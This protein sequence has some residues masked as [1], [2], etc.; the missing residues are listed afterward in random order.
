MLNFVEMHSVVLE[1]FQQALSIGMNA[2]SFQRSQG[3]RTLLWKWSES[4]VESSGIN[5]SNV[6]DYYNINREINSWQTIK[7]AM[8][9]TKKTTNESM[10]RTQRIFEWI[11]NKEDLYGNNITTNNFVWSESN[12]QRF[13]SEE[14]FEGHAVC[15]DYH[16]SNHKEYYFLRR[17]TA[18]SDRGVLTF[19]EKYFHSIFRVQD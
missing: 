1:Q 13:V 6:S 14:W 12:K 9:I 4:G 15:G 11:R 5:E 3:S 10:R 19:G 8:E 2:P 16:G 7:K 18:Q 17:D